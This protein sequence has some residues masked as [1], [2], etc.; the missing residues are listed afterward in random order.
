MPPC[1]APHPAAR[2]S[3]EPRGDLPLPPLG[4]VAHDPL[5][6]RSPGSGL[7]GRPRGK[8][9]RWMAARRTALS[10]LAPDAG[11]APAADLSVPRHA[12]GR[13]S[14]GQARAT[15]L[16]ST[17]HSADARAEASAT[18]STGAVSRRLR[19]VHREDPA[20]PRRARTD[21]TS[22]CRRNASRAGLEERPRR[23]FDDFVCTSRLACEIK[24]A[25]SANGLH[26]LG[27]QPRKG[28]EGQ[29]RVGHPWRRKCGAG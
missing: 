8:H 24:D 17:T 23:E 14:S 18:C 27:G 3:A 16:S 4:A 29:P 26:I 2:G 15:R 25:L 11:S 21:L 20:R 12:P 22:A 9:C 10:V 13:R 7:R 5:G 6:Y 19:S 1:L 28:R